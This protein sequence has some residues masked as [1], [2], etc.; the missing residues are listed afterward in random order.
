MGKVQTEKQKDKFMA[1]IIALIGLIAILIFCAIVNAINHDFSDLYA[2]IRRFDVYYYEKIV[3]SG[4]NHSGVYSQMSPDVYGMMNGMSVWAFFPLMPLC[5]K[6]L[7]ILT[8][9][10]I[11]NYVLAIMLSTFCMGVMLYFLVR[12]LRLINVKIN[13]FLIAVLFV[14]NTYFLFYFNFYT[15]AMFMMLIAIFLYLCEEKKFLES[16]IVLAL[17]TATRVTGVFFIFYLFYKIYQQIELGGG[18]NT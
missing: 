1:I 17:M 9:G 14:F 7:S 4:Y 13:Y 10:L 3:E 2:P 18:G 8:F 15:E 16:G 12:F 5:V 11:D 6:M